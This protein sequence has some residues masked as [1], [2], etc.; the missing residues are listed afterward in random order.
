[1]PSNHSDAPSRP[2]LISKGSRYSDPFLSQVLQLPSPK[3]S[4]GGWS[5]WEMGLEYLGEGGW[6]TWE[7]G[8]EYLGEGGWS[9]WESEV[10]VFG[11]GKLEYLGE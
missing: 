1:M 7:R 9:T 5:T 11:R 3:Y 4:N 6:S 10:G 2:R 8:L